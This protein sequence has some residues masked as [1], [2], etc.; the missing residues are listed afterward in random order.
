MI[1]TMAPICRWQTKITTGQ[2]FLPLVCQQYQCLLIKFTIGTHF[3]R[4]SRALLAMVTFYDVTKMADI[5]YALK[6]TAFSTL[7]ILVAEQFFKSIVTYQHTK[8]QLIK[9]LSVNVGMLQV[10]IGIGWNMTAI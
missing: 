2:F 9:L 1:M 5:V 8:I 3:C 7:N 4:R 6:T 10:F